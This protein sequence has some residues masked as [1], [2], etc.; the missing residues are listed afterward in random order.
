MDRRSN[1][2]VG[3][4]P[5]HSGGH[6]FSAACKYAEGGH[7]PSKVQ[8]GGMLASHIAKDCQAMDYPPLCLFWTCPS[9]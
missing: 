2:G 5:R 8:V 1:W 6:P 9:T 4:S 3:D 7:R